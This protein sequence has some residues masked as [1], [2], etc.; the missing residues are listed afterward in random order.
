M[1]RIYYIDLSD[2][3]LLSI[4]SVLYPFAAIR[5]LGII[6]QLCEF[7]IIHVE[8]KYKSFFPKF[9]NFCKILLKIV[10]ISLFHGLCARYYKKN[11]ITFV[12][13]IDKPYTYLIVWLYRRFWRRVFNSHIDRI[14]PFVID[15]RKDSIG[16]FRR[17][18]LF[19]IYDHNPVSR[20]I[21][22][23]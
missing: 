20:T 21:M 11:L 10:I 22:W 1:Y 7:I 5:H 13:S 8:C 4:L 16:K 6:R 23:S 3:L 18:V 15:A 12:N 17:A 9:S 14:N 2:C 19:T